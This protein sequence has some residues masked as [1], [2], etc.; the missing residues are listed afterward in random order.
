MEIIQPVAE[1]EVIDYDFMFTS[2]AKLVVTLDF[3]AG[4]KFQETPDRF[5]LDITSKPSPA[6]PEDKTDEETLEVFKTGLAA[7]NKCK[8]MQ[9]VP[10]EEEL[11]QMRKTLHTAAKLIQ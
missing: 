8:R 2:G 3:A 9:R 4:D 7:L 10:S 1:K 11:F 5:I 6:D